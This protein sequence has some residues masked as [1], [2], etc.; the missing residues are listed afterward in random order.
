MD[1]AQKE[2]RLAKIKETLQR[3]RHIAL[4]TVNED[5]SP[6]NSVVFAAWDSS[7]HLIWSSH[8]DTQHSRNIARDGQ[9]FI[10]LFD[11]V[12]KGG[13]LYITA[14]AQ[15]VADKELPDVLAAFNRKRKAILRQESPST[16]FTGDGPQR[17][18]VAVPQKIWINSS[19]RDKEGNS[20]YD[21]RVEITLQE[22]LRV[23]Y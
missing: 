2:A 22:A 15:Q 8:T 4:A 14:H 21:R 1:V 3:V 9:V 5:G 19:E 18:Y 17:L 16:L 12:E 20:M 10:V 13:G 11:S 6:H 23:L 7:G